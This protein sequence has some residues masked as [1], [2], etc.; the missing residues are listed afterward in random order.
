MAESP[1]RRVTVLCMAKT[2]TIRLGSADRTALE[3]AAHEQGKGLSTLV[4]ELAETE[5][6]RVRREAIKADGERVMAH[7]EA[8]PEAQRELNEIGTPLSD[9]Q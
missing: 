5:A 6:E 4:R 3:L 2:L 8:H 9:P 7:L 1:H